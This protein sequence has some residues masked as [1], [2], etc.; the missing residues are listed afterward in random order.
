MLNSISPSTVD[1]EPKTPDSFEL[2][3]VLVFIA[4]MIST[5]SF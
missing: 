1:K 5:I 4:K 2:S 3:G